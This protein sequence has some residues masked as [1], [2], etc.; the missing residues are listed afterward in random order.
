LVTRTKCRRSRVDPFALISVAVFGSVARGEATADSD[1]DLLIIAKDE[2]DP[3]SDAWIGQVDGLERRT[4]LRIGNSLQITT[5][6]Q[7]QLA[8]MVNS[9]A[10][11]IDEWDRDAHTIMGQDARN[12]IRAA[13]KKTL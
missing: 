12:L 8:A 7:T 6:T 11:I 13:R 9:D 1:L 3:E 4:R 10:P 2:L 5:V